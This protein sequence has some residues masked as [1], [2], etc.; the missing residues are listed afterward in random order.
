LPL[1]KFVFRLKKNGFLV[2]DVASAII[3]KNDGAAAKLKTK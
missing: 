2:S 3:G 1:N